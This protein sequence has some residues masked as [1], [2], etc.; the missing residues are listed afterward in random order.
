[1]DQQYGLQV[2][3]VLM[4]VMG[5]AAFLIGSMPRRK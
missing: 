4:A 5:I 2:A 1:M 3:F